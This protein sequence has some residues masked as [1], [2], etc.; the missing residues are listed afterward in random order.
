MLKEQENKY[1]NIEF[2]KHGK[3]LSGDKDDRTV[4]P[5]EMDLNL[6]KAVANGRAESSDRFSI[7][8]GDT[9][10]FLQ[11]DDIFEEHIITNGGGYSLIS[12]STI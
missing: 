1:Q 11:L 5:P 4:L 12:K 7:G 9:H 3:I 8:E 2:I 10:R 6:E